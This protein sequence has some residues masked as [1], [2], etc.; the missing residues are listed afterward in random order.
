MWMYMFA[1]D[2][3]I[4]Y[5]ERP[6]LKKSLTIIV[7]FMHDYVPYPFTLLI[8]I[9]TVCDYICER[10][11]RDSCTSCVLTVNAKAKASK[12]FNGSAR[13]AL[14]LVGQSNTSPV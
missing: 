11:E 2:Y 6:K 1:F 8:C 9:I 12:L 13:L 7:R 10:Y 3:P 14:G 4:G 5:L